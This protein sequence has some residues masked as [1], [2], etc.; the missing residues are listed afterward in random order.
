VTKFKDEYRQHIDEG[1]C[2]FGGASSL[3]GVVAPSDQET[4]APIA[5]VPA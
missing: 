5:E 4:H 1:G 2:P 3:E